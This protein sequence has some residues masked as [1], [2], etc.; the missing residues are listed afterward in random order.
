MSWADEETEAQG[1]K[2]LSPGRLAS[3]ATFCGV[4]GRAPARDW[5]GAAPGSWLSQVGCSSMPGPFPR[6][7]LQGGVP[8]VHGRPQKGPEGSRIPSSSQDDGEASFRSNECMSR[9]LSWG[10]W[11]GREL[12]EGCTS[13]SLSVNRQNR[14]LGGDSGH[15]V[16]SLSFH[17]CKQGKGE[18]MKCA[19]EVTG[20]LGDSN[21]GEDKRKPP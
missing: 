9:S 12:R 4:L 21:G 16:P 11:A 3:E 1:R 18:S 15:T 19:Q 20:H 5:V 6:A 13:V 10:F 14:G 2:A 8:E 7:G 17:M